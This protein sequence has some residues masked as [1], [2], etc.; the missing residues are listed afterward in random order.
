[1]SCVVST[2]RYNG[3]VVPCVVRNAG[4]DV[5]Y[6]INFLWVPTVLLFS[7]KCSLFMWGWL[8]GFPKKTEKN[9]VGFF[10]FTYNYKVIKMVFCHWIILSF[11]SLLIASIT[12]SLKQG[13]NRLGQIHS[14][15]K[16]THRNWQW[17]SELYDKRDNF[18]FHVVNFP[19]ICD[20]IP[21]VLAYGL[22]ISQ[23]IRYSGTCGFYHNLIDRWLLL[24]SN[25]L[26][27]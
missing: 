12:M 22:Y 5:M 10:N 2:E 24:T 27:Q 15:S 7:P 1:M 20:Y 14:I 4:Y 11:V 6:S 17:V 19:Y 8:T 26:N 13:Y 21:A 3:C 9:L 16:P 23:L 18:N 25:L